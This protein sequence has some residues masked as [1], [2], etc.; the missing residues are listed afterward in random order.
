MDSKSCRFCGGEII[1]RM[2]A[3]ACVPL[4]VGDQRCVVHSRN[5]QP[6]RCNQARCP[7]CGKDVFFV[8]HN[9]GSVWFE[10]LGKP[11]D[12]HPCFDDVPLPEALATH[13]EFRLMRIREVARLRQRSGYVLY[14]GRDRKRSEEWEVDLGLQSHE[15]Q[16]LTGKWCYLA[17]SE[18]M[19]ALLDGR[20]FPASRHV[21][22]RTT[23]RSYF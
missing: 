19:I 7:R 2:I 5:G 16:R 8:R 22:I 10:E 4:H 12:K 14:L 1:F 11:W 21:P 17:Q 18:P 9:C 3:T 20:R 23:R 15:A 6:D 13:R